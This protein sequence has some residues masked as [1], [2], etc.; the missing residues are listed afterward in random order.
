MKK[1]N[2]TIEVTLDE[3]NVP[4]QIK[5]N[6]DDSPSTIPQDSKAISLSV[7][8]SDKRDTLNLNIWTKE[9]DVMEMKQFYVNLLGSAS[10]TVL[11]ATGD[12][13]MSSEIANLCEKLVE[14]LK[15]Q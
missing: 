3:S 11:N 15:K 1:S 4:E 2:I 9:M 10:N 5:W 13:F 6:A 8:D 12:E 14:Y 7:W